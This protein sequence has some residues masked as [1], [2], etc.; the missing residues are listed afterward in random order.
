MFNAGNGKYTTVGSTSIYNSTSNTA[1]NFTSYTHGYNLISNRTGYYATRAAN[2]INPEP[3][4]QG[5]VNYFSD[6]NALLK[7]DTQKYIDNTQS[8]GER[9]YYTSNTV[10]SYYMRVK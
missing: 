5:G 2:W 4:L 10:L 7:I 6:G 3:V 1:P 9:S 8:A